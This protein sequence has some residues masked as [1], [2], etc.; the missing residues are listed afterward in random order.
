MT[1]LELSEKVKKEHRVILKLIRENIYLFERFGKM[2][3]LKF[4]N[5]RGKNTKFYNL[6]ED[7]IKLFL[8]KI[9]ATT[10]FKDVCDTLKVFASD[11][12]IIEV[13]HEIELKRIIES[14][15]KGFSNTS[16]LNLKLETQFSVGKNRLDMCIL[17]EIDGWF[18][19]IGIEIDEELTHKYTVQKDLKRIEDIR[20]QL[21]KNSQEKDAQKCKFVS[22]N[23]NNIYKGIQEIIEILNAD[24]LNIK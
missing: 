16:I 19:I 20:K 1:T 3:E 13:R 23:T 11:F 12:S 21:D 10:D 2:E 4:N 6:N 14:I 9:S 7:H 5:H 22:I 18:P 24:F 17:S 15:V 8:N